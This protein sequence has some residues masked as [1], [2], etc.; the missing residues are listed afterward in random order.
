[1]PSFRYRALTDSGEL[2]SRTITAA[3]AAEGVQRIEMLGL[4]P[5][6]NLIEERPASSRFKLASLSRPRPEEITILTRDLALLLRAGVRIND[7]LEL[8]SSDVDIGRLRPVVADLRTAV[9][10]GESFAEA[11]AHHPALFPPLYVALI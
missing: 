5:I 8:L 9:V 7:A 1:M 10:G 11:L 4:V 6:D 3:S 2:V